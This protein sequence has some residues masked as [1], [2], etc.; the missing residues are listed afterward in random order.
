AEAD[1]A[2]RQAAIATAAANR[3]TNA[4]STAQALAG[5]AAAA[6]RTARDAANS[7]AD[8]ADKAATAAEEAVKYAGQAIDY[9][10][11]STAHAGEAVKA[12]NVATKAVTD[13]IEV[14]KNARAAEA[15]TLEQDKQ[16]AM[17]EAQLLASIE[18]NDLS[19]VRDKRLLAERTAQEIKDLTTRAE[20][21]LYSGDFALAGTLGRKAAI[22]R[23]DARGAWTR[24]AAQ[25]AL[26]GSDDDIFAWID[27]DRALAEAQDD[28]ETALHVATVA[29][30]QI[31]EAAQLALASS[32]S[33]AVGDFLTIGMKKASDEELRVAI[34]KIL[35]DGAGKAVTEAGNKALDKNT[36][37]SLNYF[38]DHDYPLAQEE[39]DKVLAGQLIT[40]GGAFTKAYAE[41]ALEGPAW[42]L[43]NFI[44]VVQFQTAQFDHD[45]ATHVAAI[46]GAIAAASKIAYQ[47]Q[48]NAELATQAA[49][50][51]R[52]D[53]AKAQEWAD[54]A[55]DSAK[56]A[57]SYADEARANADAADKSAADAQASADK[58]KAAAATAR[59]A[60]RSANYAANKAID[61]ARAAL[62]SS[63]DAQAS[64]NAARAAKLAAQA[65]A[66]EAAAAYSDAKRIV[67]EKH[68]AEVDAAAKAALEAAKRYRGNGQDPADN[69][70]N[71]QVNPNG[72]KDPADSDEW[73]NDAQWYADA[74]NVVSIGAGFLAAGCTLAGFV[75][76]PA[77][78]AAG[79]FAEVS[80]GASAISTVF[81]GIEHGFTSS[82]F[83]W[84]AASTGLSLVTFGVSK[85]LGAAAKP[86]STLVKPVVGKIA[87]VVEDGASS[88]TRDLYRLIS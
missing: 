12:A 7:A 82:E 70:R 51:A 81:T 73:W 69:G 16:Q 80:V 71:N 65:D 62:K 23:I 78:V 79:F 1:E 49:Y 26:A 61:S 56:K 41:V 76:P 9:A 46:R 5:T 17:E 34:V 3:A 88:I 18:A 45:T 43:R 33:T 85:A 30:P 22:G 20:Q 11:K 44:S 6:A 66:K 54:K 25:H 58:A 36:T 77:F 68:R 40:T 32:S 10:N 37:E 14:E 21:A 74:A 39:D 57:D 48:Q 83:G 15:Q 31:A 24:Q 28:R 2:K 59:G 13:A 50:E 4:A 53:A 75:F 47:A 29:A 27:L 63:A 55:I 72:T 64:A 35:N 67:A 38:F 84:S 60:A 52:N 8:H 19:D 87:G 86:A 42:M